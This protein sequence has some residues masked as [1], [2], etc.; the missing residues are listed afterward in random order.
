MVRVNN[1]YSRMQMREFFKIADGPTGK[2]R[3]CLGSTPWDMSIQGLPFLDF[4]LYTM[5]GLSGKMA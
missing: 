5:R 2:E 1:Y 3:Q 4:N